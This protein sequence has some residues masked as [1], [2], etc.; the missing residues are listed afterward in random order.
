M[1]IGLQIP[2]FSWPGSP[3]NLG[4]KLAAIARAADETSFSS[5][6]VMDHYFQIGSV[7]GTTYKDPMLEGYTALSFMAGATRRVRLGTMVTGANYRQPGFLVK[8][9]SSLDVLSGG[10]AWLG[11]GAGWNEQE[12]LGLGL[13]FPPLK[14]RFERLEETL[15]IALKMWSGDFSPY[16]GKHYH[17]GEPVNSPQPISKPH[18]PILIGGSGEQKTL[19]LVA[20]YADACNLFPTSNEVLAHKLDVLK[21]HC[22]EVGRNYTDI[23][24]TM[25][26]RIST[27][28]NGNLATTEFINNCKTWA[29]L[30]IQHVIISDVP[31]VQDIKP[32]EVI[33]REVI[34]AVAGL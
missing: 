11:I 2:R 33:G 13:P 32:L 29:K 28:P 24:K 18:P 9:V 17:L 4:E 22:D 15:Q 27:E 14:E 10:R 30:G 31:N 19:R 25:L 6:W 21:H 5:I 16:D 12:A 34:P 8:V 1:K 26:G 20:K 7:S 23:E 3:N